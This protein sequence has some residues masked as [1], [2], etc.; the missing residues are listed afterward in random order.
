MTKNEAKLFLYNFLRKNG[1]VNRYY[2]N[3]IYFNDCGYGHERKQFLK[4]KPRDRLKAIMSSHINAY[5]SSDLF[6][7]FDDRPSSFSW[8]LSPEGFDYWQKWWIKWRE[9]VL[10]LG[11]GNGKNII[12]RE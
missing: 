1:I 3:C 10:S 5:Q 8:D 7:F 4:L 9:E 2:Y 11:V 6:C 12:T